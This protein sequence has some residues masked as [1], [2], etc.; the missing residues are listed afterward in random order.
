MSRY[1]CMRDVN[2]DA[3]ALL[4]AVCDGCCFE[5]L[6]CRCSVMVM[7]V[8]VNLFQRKFVFTV[9]PRV[10]FFRSKILCFKERVS[11]LK[12]ALKLQ[13]SW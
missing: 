6:V 12:I 5:C 9:V 13:L 7:A 10:K 3:K 8:Y 4:V 2:V 1:C 11:V